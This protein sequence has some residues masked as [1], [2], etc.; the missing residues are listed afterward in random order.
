MWRVGGLTEAKRRNLKALILYPNPVKFP[1]PRHELIRMAG[2][3]AKRAEGKRNEFYNILWD[4]YVP[5]LGVY[6]VIYENE[7]SENPM[8]GRGKMK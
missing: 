6:V 7:L 1:I 5:E 8:L 3:K 2:S 4:E